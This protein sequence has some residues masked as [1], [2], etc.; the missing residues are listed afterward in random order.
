MGL[1]FGF[2]DLEIDYLNR[3]ASAARAPANPNTPLTVLTAEL[4]FFGSFLAKKMQDF[5]Y[6]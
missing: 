4:T 3:L 5:L 1:R 6:L 2:S